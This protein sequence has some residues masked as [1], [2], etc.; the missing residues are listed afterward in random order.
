MTTIKIDFGLAALLGLGSF[1]MLQAIG[2]S[3]DLL[4]RLE[5]PR[6]P[7]IDYSEH[8]DSLN[9][10]LAET[11]ARPR[12][13]DYVSLSGLELIK[14]FEG[15]SAVPYH[16]AAGITTIGYGHTR[17]A[18]RRARITEDEAHDL[19]RE[20]LAA[21]ERAVTAGVRIPLEQHEYD[22]LVSLAFNIGP[23]AFSRSTLLRR[24][25]EG[26]R[27]AAA[28][29]F[30]DWRFVGKRPNTGL[31]RRRAAEREFFLTPPPETIS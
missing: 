30:H 1:L 3:D 27:A 8:R 28:K 16:D 20:D 14:K 12:T 31:I 11:A 21:A 5:G 15:F 24:L 17:T 29:R 26:D 18:G 25:N 13:P 19:L 9:R 6:A 7:S 10:L 23:G 2:M 4:A 22:A